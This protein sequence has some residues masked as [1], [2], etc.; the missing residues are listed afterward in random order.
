MRRRSASDESVV[1]R[2]QANPYAIEH[3]SGCTSGGEIARLTAG[4]A[5]PW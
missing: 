4:T 3:L 5:A 1:E 2:G